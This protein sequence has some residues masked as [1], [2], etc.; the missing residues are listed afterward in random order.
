MEQVRQC[1]KCGDQ[2][3]IELFQ[4]IVRPSGVYYSH[5]CISCKKKQD[6][7]YYILNKGKIDQRQKDY[8]LIEE[9]KIAKQQFAK[10]Y[11]IENKE[12][13]RS[14]QDEYLSRDDVK[15]R[16]KVYDKKYEEETGYYS[17]YRKINKEK[18]DSAR[19][20]Y[21]NNRML[22]D[23]TFKL[24]KRVSREIWGRLKTAGSSKNG[25]I[26]DYLPYTIDQLR[27][28]L[29]SQFQSWMSWGNWGRYNKK[30]WKDDDK[31]TWTWQIDHI[32]PQSDLPY[33]SMNDD[34]FKKCWA[35]EN[36][37]PLNAKENYLDGITRKRHTK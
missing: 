7:E 11:Y 18:L 3:D 37:R 13:I 26:Q 36:L 24:R 31:T 21:E 2:L 12:R 33:S 5:I 29:E 6:Q 27:S 30:Q 4:K 28:H 10:Q 17:N 14:V 35:L 23:I 32:V 20:D 34:N 16:R 25:G 22:N 9:N 8:Y 1:K 19:R 15:L